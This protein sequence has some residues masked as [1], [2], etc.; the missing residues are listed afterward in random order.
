MSILTI[1]PTSTSCIRIT[2]EQNGIQLLGPY[3]WSP[4]SWTP[5]LDTAHD[6]MLVGFQSQILSHNNGAI[7][8]RLWVAGAA[9]DGQT[10]LLGKGSHG[11]TVFSMPL[12]W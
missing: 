1:V 4:A 5:P 10:M 7:V 12:A 3:A 8:S 9:F 2:D 6:L 11:R